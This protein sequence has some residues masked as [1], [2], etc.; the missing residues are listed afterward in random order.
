MATA[1]KIEAQLIPAKLSIITLSGEITLDDVPVA[2]QVLI[3]KNNSTCSVATAFS[4]AVTG[5]WSVEIV[6]GGRDR[7]RVVAVAEDNEY[8]QIHDHIGVS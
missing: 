2:R 4:D 8:P 7:F 3:Y 1:R 5:L 6:G